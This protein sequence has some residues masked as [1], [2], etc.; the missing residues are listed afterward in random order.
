ML[1]LLQL[2]GHHTTWY[3]DSARMLL[4]QV[5]DRLLL[6]DMTWNVLSAEINYV[7]IRIYG[8]ASFLFWHILVDNDDRIQDLRLLS[9]YKHMILCQERIVLCILLMIRVSSTLRILLIDMYRL[10]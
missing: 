9:I 2:D 8:G 1:L 7:L 5:V 10:L 6:Y 3:V 4:V